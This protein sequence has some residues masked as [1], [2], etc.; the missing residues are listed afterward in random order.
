MDVLSTNSRKANKTHV[1]DFCCLKIN[2]GERYQ[3]QTLVNDV[4]YKWKS[5]LSCLELTNKLKMWDW[6]DDG[7]TSDSF[8]EYVRDYLSDNEIKF[9]TWEDGLNKVK[10]LLCDKED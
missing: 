8:I 7:L 5:H 1:C 3:E 2:K 4:I 9:T 10:Q 6:C